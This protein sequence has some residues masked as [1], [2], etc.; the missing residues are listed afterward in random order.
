[1]TRSLVT[2]IGPADN[3]STREMT[4]K[5][6]CAIYSSSSAGGHP[7][8]RAFALSIDVGDKVARVA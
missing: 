7:I 3:V 5:L 8:D 4:S 6:P 1:M 2:N